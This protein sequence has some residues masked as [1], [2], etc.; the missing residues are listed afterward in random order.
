VTNQTKEKVSGYRE[1]GE[2]SY[3]DSKKKKR[4]ISLR[5]GGGRGL[6]P[7]RS[8]RGI[9]DQKEPERGPK[10]CSST[11]NGGQSPWEDFYNAGL[12]TIKGK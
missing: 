1:W 5:S 6:P 12:V 3:I 10:G 7:I 2:D 8:R 9:G 11:R 4:E